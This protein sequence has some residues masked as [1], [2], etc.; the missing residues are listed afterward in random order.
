VALVKERKTE[1]IN[2]FK[3]HDND[4]GSPNVQIALL[5]DRLNGLTEHFKMHKNDHH[6]R[7][8]LL[9]LVSRRRRLLDYLKRQDT[10]AYQEILEKLNL[11]K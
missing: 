9:E 4:T 8:G 1:V 7:K 3:I 5:T 11:R 2:S 10:K 6:S